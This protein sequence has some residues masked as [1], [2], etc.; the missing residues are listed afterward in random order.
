MV[1]FREQ[2]PL[3]LYVMKTYSEAL[4]AGLSPREAHPSLAQL[5]AGHTT[6]S[7]IFRVPLE[8]FRLHKASTC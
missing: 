4:D 8:P 1:L 7:A 6:S 3:L 5:T 2:E